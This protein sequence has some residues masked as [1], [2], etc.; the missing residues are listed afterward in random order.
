[1]QSS[2]WQQEASV[3][4]EELEQ[5]V[6]EKNEKRDEVTNTGLRRL[7]RYLRKE[8]GL[9]WECRATYAALMAST[10]YV[11]LPAKGIMAD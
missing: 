3:L 1:M 9:T 5:H 4:E 6:A 10:G 2:R 7:A 8:H 11:P